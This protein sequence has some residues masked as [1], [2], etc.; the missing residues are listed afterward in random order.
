MVRALA[1]AEL[2][3][4]D[5]RRLKVVVTSHQYG[6][7]SCSLKGG[8]TYE[9]CL[10]L[11][12]MQEIL[13]PI[14]NSRYLMVRKMP[15]LRWIRKDYHVVPQARGRNKESAEYF[16]KMWAKYVGPTELIYTRSVKGRKMLLKA[17][18]HA[19]SASFQQ[20]SERVRSWK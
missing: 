4:S 16:N 3:K 2:V 14:G 7:V 17:R 9:K 8:A 13:G 10:F 19:M 15:L 20:R 1:H 5:I 11:D 12:S 6:V 18:G